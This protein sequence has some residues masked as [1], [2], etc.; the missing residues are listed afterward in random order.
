M[1]FEHKDT[2]L[3]RHILLKHSKLFCNG[4]VQFLEQIL[5]EILSFDFSIRS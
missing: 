2:K 5:P 1:G 3:E 4:I